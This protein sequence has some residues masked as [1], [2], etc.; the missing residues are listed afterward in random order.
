MGKKKQ[1]NTPE[2][3]ERAKQIAELGYD[4]NQGVR[5]PGSKGTYYMLEATRDEIFVPDDEPEPEPEVVEKEAEPE[6]E[7]PP[8][9][10]EHTPKAIVRPVRP[11]LQAGRTLAPQRLM[12]ALP[13][14]PPPAETY[15]EVIEGSNLLYAARSYHEQLVKLEAQREAMICDRSEMFDAMLRNHEYTYDQ[16]SEMF[17]IKRSTLYKMVKD[18][19]DD[20]LKKLEKISAIQ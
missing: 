6:P 17:E 19:R 13:P 4:P 18:F 1:V 15:H 2:S 5:Y 11:Q 8:A 10:P 3:I 16:L 7:A 12:P 20:K 9:E 14:P